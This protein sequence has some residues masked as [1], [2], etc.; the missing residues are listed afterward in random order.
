MVLVSWFKFKMLRRLNNFNS[1][2]VINMSIEQD[3]VSNF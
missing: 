1:K 2:V 3:C